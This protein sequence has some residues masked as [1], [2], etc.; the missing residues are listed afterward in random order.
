MEM[1]L[2]KLKEK[3]KKFFA[4]SADSRYNPSAP[5]PDENTGREI[6]TPKDDI[7]GCW[8]FKIKF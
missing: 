6:E 8:L 5:D 4:T 7:K 1:L 2:S 3:L